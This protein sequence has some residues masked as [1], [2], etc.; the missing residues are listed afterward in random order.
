MR[1]VEK[2]FRVNKKFTRMKILI[3]IFLLVL[4]EL[5]SSVFAQVT[6]AEFVPESAEVL[7]RYIQYSSVSGNETAAGEYFSALCRSKGLHVRMLGNDSVYNF[8]AS[9]YPLESGKPNIIFFNHIDVVPPGDTSTWRY[10]AFSGTIADGMV[11]GRGALDLKGLA[12]MQMMSMLSVKEFAS[13]YDLPYNVT[14]LCVSLEET[15]SAGANFIIDRHLAELFPLVVFGEGGAGI[16]GLIS[17]RPERDVFC[18]STAEKQ[19]FWLRVSVAANTSGHGAIPP[20]EYANQILVNGLSRL[21]NRRQQLEFNDSN[22][23]M[24]SAMGRMDKGVR[25]LALRNIR[26]FKPFAAPAF[27]NDPNLMAVVSNTISLTQLSNPIGGTNQIAQ[28]ASALLDCRLLPGTDPDKFLAKVK[29]TLNHP[30][31]S[32]DVE[33]Q[34]RACTPSTTSNSFYQSMSTS[35]K[36]VYPDAEV[37]PYLFPA[38]TDNNFFRNHGIPVYGVN[39]IK[40]SPTLLES[41]HNNDER[42]P[43]A[44]LEEG[45][46]VYKIFLHKI[47]LQNNTASV[48]INR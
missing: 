38:Y 27:R 20:K 26:W 18:I 44:S 43:I 9:L 15:S 19:A 25:A 4:V 5:P 12:V 24:F 17:S 30:L 47:L 34:T 14:L 2:Y 48:R 1:W 40:L 32:V 13:A 21:M 11:W 46:Q 35:L 23:P 10:P 36:E 41:I 28:Q 6:T 3:P 16:S 31:I 37:M 7:S 45:I 39:P 8:A 22:L 33:L 42:I 29:R